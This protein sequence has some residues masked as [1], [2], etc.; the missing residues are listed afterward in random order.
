MGYHKR[1]TFQEGSHSPCER[2]H[3]R[4]GTA[5]AVLGRSFVY[6]SSWLSSR[7]CPT[8]AALSFRRANPLNHPDT[9]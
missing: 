2:C 7:S 6:W 1:R 9:L 4:P 8:S 3:R 5:V